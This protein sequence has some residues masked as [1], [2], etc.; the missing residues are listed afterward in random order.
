MTRTS[1]SRTARLGVLAA[2]LMTLLTACAGARAT[3]TG[4]APVPA[5][6]SADEL[7]AVTL[8]IGDQ[9]AGLEA[10]LKAAGE[11][12]APYTVEWSN[13]TSGPPL[14][15]AAAANAIDVGT[16]GN[17]PPI[18]AGAAKSPV[19]VVS[20]SRYNGK[21]DAILVP[22]DSPATTLADL[23]GKTVAVAKGSSAHGHLLLALLQA[24]LSPEDITISYVAP[25]DGYAALQN[26]AA[27]AWV[28][29]DPYTTAATHEIKARILDDGEGLTNGLGFQVA[30]NDSLGDPGKNAAISDLVVRTARAYQWAEQHPDEW[31]KVYAAETGLSEEI[32][33]EMARRSPKQPILL[34]DTVVADT[35]KLADALAENGFIP[36]GFDFS[37][38]VD[39]RYNDAV[40]TVIGQ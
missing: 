11:D 33:Q 17:T 30:S 2:V 16:V 26:G 10:L 22:A 29:W 32:T 4:P 6:V 13:F 21:A 36:A 40:S 24:G 23:K 15:E 20:A 3:T 37:T 34:D 18:F 38:I 39:R 8:K 14:L 31:G 7:A 9:K 27:D 28:V 1:L 35:Q 19:T 25:S 12:D 5:S